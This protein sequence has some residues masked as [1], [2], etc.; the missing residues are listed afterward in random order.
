MSAEPAS[1][2]SGEISFLVLA[3][4]IGAVSAMLRVW[5]CLNDFWLDEI[6]SWTMAQRVTSAWQIIAGLHHDNNHYLNTLWMYLLGDQRDWVLYRVPALVG[7]T[8]AVIAAGLGQRRRDRIAALTA[9]LLLGVSYLL[10]LYSSEA[11]GYGPVMAFALFAFFAAQRHLED[12]RWTSAA[13][14]WLSS[15]LGFLSTLTFSSCYLGILAWS[16]VR[17]ARERRDWWQATGRAARMHVVPVAFVLAV[18]L[19]DVRQMVIG[20]GPRFSLGSVLESAFA[21]ALGA[22]QSGGWAI[23]ASSC[24]LLLWAA[25]VWMLWRDGS[26]VW[27][28]FVVTIGLAPLLQV[29]LWQAPVLF[30]RYWLVSVLFFLLLLS[31]LLARLYRQAVAGKIVFLALLSLF[32]VGNLSHTARLLRYGRGSYLAPLEYIVDHT[33][34]SLVTVGSDHDFRHPMVLG[35]YTR[36]LRKHSKVEYYARSEWPASGPEWFLAHSQDQ[37][38]RPPQTLTLGLGDRYALVKQY[39]YGGLSGWREFVYHNLNAP[40]PDDEGR[41]PGGATA[42]QPEGDR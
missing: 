41:Q 30:V 18:Y 15:V 7:G 28:F 11:R 34:G 39:P 19:V 35:F 6:W 2:P 33:H 26:D 5:A 1:R 3:V 42:A 37:E 17:L 13:L 12:E 20:G 31:Q 22:P 24:A 29:L 38:L 9:M 25:G 21:L 32:V 23:V 36:Y 4:A 40:R 27:V 10:V 14:F 8:T 16:G